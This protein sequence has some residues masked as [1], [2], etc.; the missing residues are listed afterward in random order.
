MRLYLTFSQCR[1]EVRRPFAGNRISM[2]RSP[3]LSQIFERKRIKR[4]YFLILSFLI[5]SFNLCYSQNLPSTSIAL[6]ELDVHSEKPLK[7]AKFLTNFNPKGY[8]NQPAFF[9]ENTLY[10]TSDWSAKGQTDIVKLNLLR[11]AMLKITDTDE[12]EYSPTLC[13]DKTHFSTITVPPTNAANPA[14]FLWRYPLDRSSSG[15]VLS[16]DLSNVGYHCWMS[17]GELALFL[18]DDPHKLVIYNIRAGSVKEVDANIGR[19]LKMSRG[20]ELIY[21]HK[22]NFNI[23]YL[24]SYNPSTG[25]KNIIGETR[26]GSEDFEILDD[27]TLMMAQQSRIYL[28]SEVGGW[29]E[30]DD[31]TRYG[32]SKVTKIAAHGNKI[33]LVYAS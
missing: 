12:S 4:P 26:P 20:S 30:I 1:K 32:I 22:A 24:K 27:G 11:E 21:V 14:Q 6:F 29:R 31:L 19:C 10:I 5:A 9:D 8:N 3:D 33:A 18:V 16:Y 25:L 13:P 2:R 28:M 15:K 17:E 7:N 23:W